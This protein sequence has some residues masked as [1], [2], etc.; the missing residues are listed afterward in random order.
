MRNSM[1]G[2]YSDVCACVSVLSMYA[3]NALT[4]S[5]VFQHSIAAQYA[6]DASLPSPLLTEQETDLL[7]FASPHGYSPPSTV[8]SVATPLPPQPDDTEEMLRVG[9]QTHTHTVLARAKPDRTYT[10]YTHYTHT[11]SVLLAVVAI[12]RAGCGARPDQVGCV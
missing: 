10:H 8:V 2:V 6:R 3:V 7:P 4:S 9:F 12:V 11:L 1:C 5:L